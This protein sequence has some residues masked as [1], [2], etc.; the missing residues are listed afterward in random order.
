MDRLLSILKTLN[1]V[2]LCLLIGCSANSSQSL[3]QNKSE[4]VYN[5]DFL[6]KQQG[7]ILTDK[8][9]C[10]IKYH[11]F[12]D[13]DRN[14]I[15][16]GITGNGKDK[17]PVVLDTGASQSIFVNTSLIKKNKLSVFSREDNAFNLNGNA[18]GIC[19]LSKLNVGDITLTDWPCIY[20]E[21]HISLSLLG[22]P[23][24]S[25]TSGHE[26]IILGLPL[27]RE[28]KYI[29]FD[30][31]NKEAELSYKTSFNPYDV[32]LWNKLPISIEEDFHGNAFL[33]VS[34]NISGV[35]TELQ[36]DTGSGRGLAVNENLWE[37]IQNNITKVKLKKGKEYYPYIGN[38]PCEK[39]KVPE[40]DFEG[41]TINNM[42][43]CV[44]P[45]D[46]PLLD[47]CEGLIGMQF[48]QNAMFVLDFEHDIMWLSK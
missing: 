31:I 32:N 44:F 16:E 41:R 35:E 33:F 14:I 1:Y 48:F 25:S 21:P 45:E 30:N 22:I 9:T 46:S 34:F 24:A 28:F 38:L 17:Y 43:I 39:G 13:T 36:L 4:N 11:K 6:I 15:V 29:K 3:K 40:I 27:L 37:Q 20:L 26:N 47:E 18:I 12:S 42:E 8:R 10:R 7:K 2:I 5:S 19:M 23:I